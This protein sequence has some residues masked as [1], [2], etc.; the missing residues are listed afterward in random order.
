[1]AN[2]NPWLRLP[3]AL[4]SRLPLPPSAPRHV[5]EP[6]VQAA[7]ELPPIRHDG[8]GTGRRGAEPSSDSGAGSGGGQIRPA[9]FRLTPTVVFP[10]RWLRRLQKLPRHGAGTP[11]STTRVPTRRAAGPQLS[12]RRVISTFF[13][14]ERPVIFCR[15]REPSLRAPNPSNQR[16]S[17][18]FV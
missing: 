11:G 15:A 2:P 16:S 17:A 1:M 4:P 8:G 7:T 5:Q 18:E 12:L 13:F 3:P 14:V 6:G 9:P 10:L